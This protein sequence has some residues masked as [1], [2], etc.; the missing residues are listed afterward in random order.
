MAPMIDMVFLL[1]VFFMTV[2]TLAREARPELE[3]AV[4]TTA[5]VPAEAPPRDIVTV[6]P[7]AEGFRYFWHNRETGIDQLGGLIEAAAGAA[8]AAVPPGRGDRPRVRHLR[9]LSRHETP[10]QPG[11]PGNPHRGHDR[12]RVPDAG[13]FHDH[14]LA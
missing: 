5:A 6:M 9:G 1:L 14:Q 11:Q 8:A 4:S 2:S 10:A 7:G 13:L 3:L 12:L